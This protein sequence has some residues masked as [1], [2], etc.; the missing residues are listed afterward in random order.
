LPRKIKTFLGC[1]WGDLQFFPVPLED[2]LMSDTSE[3][4]I[5][6]LVEKRLDSTKQQKGK[7]WAPGR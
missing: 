5:H 4:A 3:F 2:Q 6:T 1:F 7:G